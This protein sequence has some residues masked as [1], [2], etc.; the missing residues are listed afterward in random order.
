MTVKSIDFFEEIN[1][2]PDEIRRGGE[3]GQGETFS[4]YRIYRITNDLEEVQFLKLEI[5]CNSYGQEVTVSE[6][7]K[8]VHP[9]TRTVQVWE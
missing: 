8:L 5:I 1:N 3:L 7:I 9:V 6:N 4:N 2:E